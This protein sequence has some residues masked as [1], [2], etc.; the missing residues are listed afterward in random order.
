MNTSRRNDPSVNPPAANRHWR[1]C[2]TKAIR[3]G[4]S[5]RPWWLPVPQ[6]RRT[7]Q[8]V[9]PALLAG[10][11]VCVAGA[12]AVEETKASPS[13]APPT[14]SAQQPANDGPTAAPPIADSVSST[15]PPPGT[16]LS[17]IVNEV[18]TMAAADV[19]TPVLKTYVECS[20]MAY[21]LSEA[22]VI[23]LKKARVADEVV[24]V[25]LQRGAEIRAAYY[26]AKKEAAARAAVPRTATGGLDPE[27]YDYFQHYYLQSRTLATVSQNLPVY[28]Y[29]GFGPAYGY[30]SPYAY[31]APY[32]GRPGY[33]WGPGFRPGWRH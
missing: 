15:N 24:T 2:S 11:W 1:T 17:P 16:G 14:A 6:F 3:A 12:N 30:G 23:A 10:A 33:G 19:T 31:G 7:G 27:S 8:L 32:W 22:D 5:P 4:S 13:P 26:S 18:L 29:T 20:P 28:G 9:L 25:L 21:Q